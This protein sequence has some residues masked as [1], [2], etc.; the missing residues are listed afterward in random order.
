MKINRF[1]WIILGLLFLGYALVLYFLPDYPCVSLQF[2]NL[3]ALVLL[4]ISAFLLK[5]APQNSIERDG[6]DT[7]DLVIIHPQIHN[8]SRS[9]DS[10]ESP[11]SNSVS[12]DGGETS[13]PA[14]EV[15]GDD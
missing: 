11:D 14:V 15:D 2:I 1:C 12:N 3:G 9:S 4:L 13:D 8:N 7:D 6:D 5:N 10:A